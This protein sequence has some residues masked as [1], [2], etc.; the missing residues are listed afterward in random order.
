MDSIYRKMKDYVINKL[1]YAQLNQYSKQ[2]AS[3]IM[4]CEDI[5][6]RKL[7]FDKNI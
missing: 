6:K 3:A 4:N 2:Y 5:F 1:T 7:G